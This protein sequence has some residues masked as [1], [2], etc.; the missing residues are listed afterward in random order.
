M[1]RLVLILALSL[2]LIGCVGSST[3]SKSSPA[4]PSDPTVPVSPVTPPAV[5]PVVIPPVVPPAVPPVITPTIVWS[6]P[7]AIIYGTPLSAL[8]LDATVTV[9]GT[10]VYSP[11]AGAV[12]GV[13]FQ[14]LTV[15]F[16]P[17]DPTIYASATETVSVTVTPATPVIYWQSAVGITVGAPLTAKQLSATTTTGG[18]F[19]YDPPLG[20]VLKAGTS[21]LSVTFTPSSVDYVPVTTSVTQLVHPLTDPL[22]VVSLDFDDGFE[23]GYLLGLP[24]FQ[25]AGFKTTQFIITHSVDGPDYIVDYQLLAEKAAG[26]EMAAHTQTHPHLS[27]LTQSQQQT[28]IDGSIQDML[29]MWGVNSTSFAYPYGDHDL[30][31]LQIV[32]ASGVGD[33]RGTNTGFNG[34][35]NDPDYGTD[36]VSNN[37][38]LLQAYA[39]DAADYSDINVIESELDDAIANNYWVVLFFHRVDDTTDPTISTTHQLIQQISDYLV[40]KKANVVTMSQGA[41]IYHLV[42]TQADVNSGVIGNGTGN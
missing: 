34:P 1:S 22:G 17:L 20:T 25:A 26:N 18:A 31:T 36:G 32:K 27:T 12:I 29:S 7:V 2:S 13:G 10:L 39:I 3:T 11:A 15:T 33:A 6:A 9:P 23:S 28:E 8:Q 35:V 21:T 19:D 37:D 14:P 42:P 16:T 4:L 24:I 30:A 41:A 40:A 5:P 38:L